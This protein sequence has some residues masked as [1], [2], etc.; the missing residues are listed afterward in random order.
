VRRDFDGVGVAGAILQL[1][2]LFDQLLVAVAQRIQLALLAVKHV[3][4][5]LQ[6]TLEVR[7]LEF[8]RLQSLAHDA[9]G[10]R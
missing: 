9:A 8:E 7:Y 2:Y 5:F 6:C 10:A 4:Q 3:A 1:L